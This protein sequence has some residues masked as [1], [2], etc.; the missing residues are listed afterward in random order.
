MCSLKKFSK[1]NSEKKLTELRVKLVDSNYPC[2]G[3]LRVML[4]QEQLDYWG[5][6]GLRG[7]L[8]LYHHGCSCI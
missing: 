7:P 5:H 2:L 3:K 1:A 8:L 4:Q 6:E